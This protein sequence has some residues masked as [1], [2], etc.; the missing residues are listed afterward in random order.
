MVLGLT[1]SAKKD[2]LRVGVLKVL[3]FWKLGSIKEAGVLAK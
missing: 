1:Q 2:R 3:G